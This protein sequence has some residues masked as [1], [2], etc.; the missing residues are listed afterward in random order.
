MSSFNFLEILLHFTRLSTF[1]WWLNGAYTISALVSLLNT[2]ALALFHFQGIVKFFLARLLA[3]NRERKGLDFC[4]VVGHDSV[5]KRN[6]GFGGLAGVDDA[7]RSDGSDVAGEDGIVLEP[8]GFNFL[9]GLVP[10][11]EKIILLLA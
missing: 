2:S 10:T 1:D 9:F 3:R 4:F 8:H 7:N 6:K 5:L 11:L